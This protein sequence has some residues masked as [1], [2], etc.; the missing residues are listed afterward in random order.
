MLKK[1]PLQVKKLRK[2]LMLEMNRH[3]F[4]FF[5]IYSLTFKHLSN[6]PDNVKLFF[7]K[8]KFVRNKQDSCQLGLY[9]FDCIFYNSLK[10]LQVTNK[11]TSSS[12]I[13]L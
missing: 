13:F 7:Y 5:Y 10:I 9:N 8:F 11:V 3:L 2:C 4:N 6:T 1:L 12:H